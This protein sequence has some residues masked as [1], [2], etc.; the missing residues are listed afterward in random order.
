VRSAYDARAAGDERLER[1]FRTRAL[2]AA[3]LTGAVAT[4]ALPALHADA[5]PIYTR[6]VHEGLPLVVLSAVCGLGVLAFLARDAP[7]FARPLAVLAVAMVVWGWGVAQYPFLL[8]RSLTIGAGAAP[9]GTLN[10]LFVV[11][12]A[13]A[14]IVGPSLLLL[15]R[16]Q[17]RLEEA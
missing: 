7:L 1:Y 4:A 17:R 13:A 16:L 11:F 6:L 12:G 14:V 2:I 15:F 9:S 3:V 8:P 5:H 10:A